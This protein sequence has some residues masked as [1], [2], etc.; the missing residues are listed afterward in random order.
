MNVVHIFAILVTSVTA[1]Y[2]GITE[3]KSI[4]VRQLEPHECPDGSH[5]ECGESKVGKNPDEGKHWEVHNAGR[6][7]NAG[8][9]GL[10]G[11]KCAELF[12]HCDTCTPGFRSCKI[13]HD[14]SDEGG[15]Q[16]EAVDGIC[17]VIIDFDDLLCDQCVIPNG[18]RALNW[19]NMWVLNGVTHWTPS[20]YTYG[21][22]SEPN[23][24]Y[25]AWAYPASVLAIEETFS[26]MGLQITAAWNIGLNVV[27]QGFTDGE[28][29]ASYEVTLGNPADGP[30]YID[31]NSEG[32]QSLTE[33]KITTYGGTNAGYNGG[34]EHFAMDD[35]ILF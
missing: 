29:V 19:D 9:G 2:A 21:V 23:V 25:G 14:Y 12:P 11:K 20:G 4:M 3:R 30:T 7:N 27:F 1:S 16:Y 18:Y 35:L 5:A 32:F 24:A 33:L 31:L 34:G 15:L 6:V 26:I 17:A 10:S 28:E 13:C 8:G 22:T